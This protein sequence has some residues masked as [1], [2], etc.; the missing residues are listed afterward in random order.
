VNRRIAALVA[1]AA[2]LTS[3]APPA[4]AAGIAT[5]DA[6]SV[7]ED[8]PLTIGALTG[9]L[10]ND[11]PPILVTAELVTGPAHEASFSLN[12]DGSFS[13][14]PEANFHGTDSFTY[15]TRD[16]LNDPSNAATVTI[17]I[18]PINDPPTAV[19]DPGAGA[20]CATNNRFTFAEDVGWS[21]PPA[22][23]ELDF[24]DTDVDGDPIT[25]ALLADAAHGSASVELDG[26]WGYTPD[27]DYSGTFVITTNDSFTYRA[28]DGQVWSDPATVSIYILPVNDAP[29]FDAGPDT[30]N[31]AGNSGAYSAAWATSITPGPDNGVAGP[32]S[33]LEQVVDFQIEVGTPALF[34]VQPTISPTGT[35]AFT[36]A[37]GASGTSEITVVLHD[38]GG[39]DTWGDPANVHPDNASD[40]VSFDIVIGALNETPVTSGQSVD[41]TE[42]VNESIELTA[43]DADGDTIT[44]TPSDPEHGSLTMGAR[45]CAGAPSTCTQAVTYDPD[46]NYFGADSFTYTVTDGTSTSDPATVNVTIAAVNDAPTIGR[47]WRLAVAEDSG[48]ASIPVRTAMSAGPGESAQS[49]T[50]TVQ[51]NSNPS[52]FSTQPSVVRTSYGLRVSFT[53]AANRNGWAVITVRLS[54]NGGTTNGGDN[55]TDRT[56]RIRVVP[57]NDPP[58]AVNDVSFSVQR[59]AAATALAVLANDTTAPDSG[60]TLTITARTNGAHGAVAITGGGTGLTYK[61]ATGFSGTDSFTYTISDGNGGFDTA[62]VVVTVVP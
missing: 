1:A 57:L 33:E 50:L 41:A 52:L 28:W 25:T 51:G 62:T 29:T 48:P 37:N 9:V 59:N 36:P 8:T 23:C 11:L 16:L 22:T 56:F 13:Y 24:N 4:L 6:Y 60:E 21:A 53:P 2:L 15:L 7:D 31:V 58:N 46:P 19:N 54:D 45:I 5:N 49:L 39:L 27:P 17:T 12:G 10:A 34:S 32:G 26:D 35:L 61:P 14:T 44:F 3:L 38:D 30:V 42:D 18:H 20:G 43:T 47:P 40:P 55:S